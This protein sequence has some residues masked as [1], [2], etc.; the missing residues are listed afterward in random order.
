MPAVLRLGSSRTKRSRTHLPIGFGDARAVV[1]NVQKS[2][3]LAAPDTDV[4]G[5][6]AGIFDRVVQEVGQSLADQMTF[7]PDHHPGLRPER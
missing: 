5:A 6:A 2:A 1:G 7:A 3:V 4:E